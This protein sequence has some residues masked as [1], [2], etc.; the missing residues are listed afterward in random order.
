MEVFFI[1]Q[2]REIPLIILLNKTLVLV[3]LP[4]LCAKFQVQYD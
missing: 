1:K 3:L 4:Y 2:R